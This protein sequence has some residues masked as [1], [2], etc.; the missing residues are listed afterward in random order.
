MADSTV[1]IDPARLKERYLLLF[2]DSD[3]S[4]SKIKVDSFISKT[5]GLAE[6][7]TPALPSGVPG[8]MVPVPGDGLEYDQTTGKLSFTL[9]L[10]GINFV[11]FIS[12]DFQEPDPD[13]NY[14]DF[15]IVNETT[16]TLD[17]S[18]WRGIDDGTPATYTVG[19][20]DGGDG[21]RVNTG[22]VEGI[23]ASVIPDGG[24][25]PMFRL[26]LV[27][28]HVDRVTCTVP[29]TGYST[30]DTFSF[31]P[32]SA[33]GGSGSGGYGRV[34]AV[35]ADGGITDVG[36]STPGNNYTCDPNTAGILSGV[37]A[38]GG[39]GTG[40]R[41]D[42][43]INESGTVINVDITVQGY[44]Y[45][46]DDTVTFF[47]SKTGNNATGII[48]TG[49][50]ADTVV[51]L[52][53]RVFY[54]KEDKFVLVP[55]VTGAVAILS[56][57]PSEAENEI[58]NFT[59]APDSQNLELNIAE[60]KQ[61]D[62]GTY[63]PGL[64][65]A[66]DKE[67]LDNIA[68]DARQGTVI[69]IDPVLE[70][71]YLDTEEPEGISPLYFNAINLLD[72]TGDSAFHPDTIRYEVAISDSQKI[73]YAQDS[74]V[75][76]P[77]V[78][79]VV[80]TAED[81]EIEEEI[82]GSTIG[83]NSG[84]YVMTLED[85]VKYMTQKNFTT[86]PKYESTTYA[87][88]DIEIYGDDTIFEGGELTLAVS[89]TNSGTPVNLLSYSFDVIDADFSLLTVAPNTPD[90]NSIYLKAKPST[91][92]K[93]FIVNATVSNTQETK[94]VAKTITIEGTPS[95]IGSI[96]KSPADDP[97][98][99]KV[100]EQNDFVFTPSGTVI[101]ETYE[102]ELDLDSSY[103]TMVA[104]GN[105]V[106]ITFHEFTDTELPGAGETAAGAILT[107]KVYSQFATDTDQ[108]DDNGDFV[109]TTT[110]IIVLP[111]LSNPEFS[112]PNGTN[113]TEEVPET[114]TVTYDGG[115]PED[116]VTV[117]ATTE[118]SVDDV[119]LGS[120]DKW[121]MFDGEDDTFAE[122]PGLFTTDGEPDGELTIGLN[123]NN[124]DVNFSEYEIFAKLKAQT[125][126]E[127]GVEVPLETAVLKVIYHDE[128]GNR[129]TISQL[130]LNTE[131]S[132]QLT[133]A[134]SDVATIPYVSAIEFECAYGVE[135][136]NLHYQGNVRPYRKKDV[137]DVN[138]LDV[139]V[140]FLKPG[141]NKVSGS[142]TYSDT[143]LDFE[144]DELTIS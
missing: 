41:A 64:L 19:I 93:T 99:T 8:V 51:T 2:K 60:A 96:V 107:T 25:A 124:Q 109:S 133:L 139:T 126:L 66:D 21:Y 28:G 42:L 143:T 122:I 140:T 86:L 31:V 103:Y 121:N 17:S 53:D 46:T 33:G 106:S 9:G 117:T 92:T 120:E 38:D 100:G 144:S 111:S 56:L 91:A 136:Y 83:S 63:L 36:V 10:D 29:G 80:F 34:L 137:V 37:D 20:D 48:N 127:D 125:V 35:N 67:K 11:G 55:D 43:S 131:I 115:A 50:G 61:K 24:T 82:N 135:I 130:T 110:E 59:Q 1:R 87:L 113:L 30:G 47:G 89:V 114:F 44:G 78:R 32:N 118:R 119:V 71:N 84:P 85:H 112:N 52:G 40:L 39:S 6:P 74:S 104:N 90:D 69:S 108:T 49:G 57:K 4:Y 76:L 94:S 16:V 73:H 102:Y 13:L 72:E 27:G 14:G 81:Y 77:R 129:F 75:L 97:V 54:T 5:T 88:G 116:E 132:S 98:I 70:E 23:G 123:I 15:Y 141:T 105:T 79:G 134:P 142:I 138:G 95:V 22:V 12:T 18:V 101:D 58:Y 45:K 128:D 7:P 62:D 26:T 3:E 65:P 68:T